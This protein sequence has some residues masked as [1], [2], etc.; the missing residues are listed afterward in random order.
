MIRLIL[1]GVLAAAIIYIG[2]G[3]KRYY[4]IRAQLIKDILMFIEKLQQEISFLK[5]PLNKII[6]EY[7]Q[8]KKNEFTK[9][10]AVFGNN[11]GAIEV[12][13]LNCVYLHESEKE[14]LVTMMNGVSKLDAKT[15]LH[16]LEG[17]RLRFISMS[18]QANDKRDKLGQ[19]SFK[20]SVMMA[21][22]AMIIVA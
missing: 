5:P 8:G 11:S 20:L 15:L 16:N 17:Y 6:S 2:I 9:L 1:S 7:C 21:I 13:G 4:K 19:L 18:Q 22:L 10:I 12:K 3:I 14:L